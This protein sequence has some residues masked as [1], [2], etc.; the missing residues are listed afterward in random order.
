M[1]TSS[2]T[3]PR[4]EQQRKQDKRKAGEA[5][6]AQESMDLEM[7]VYIQ[8]SHDES[9]KEKE[10]KPPPFPKKCKKKVTVVKSKEYK[11]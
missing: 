10:D 11:I 7:D 6:D 8:E 4:E 9:E 1:P 2:C 3:T 5:P